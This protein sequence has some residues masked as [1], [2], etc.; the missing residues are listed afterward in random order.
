MEVLRCSPPVIIGFSHMTTEDAK[1]GG[2]DIPKGTLVNP[3]IYDAH[4]D[5]DVWGDPEVFRPERFLMADGSCMQR[6]ESFIP[7]SVGRRVC[8]GESLARDSLFLFTS[9][10]LLNFRVEPAEGAPLPTLEPRLGQT[11]LQPQRYQ[12]SMK[13]MH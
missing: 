7:F 9:Q 4:H 10:L 6:H 5:P 3:N 2:Y 8:M 11:T 1:V 12:V 13:Y